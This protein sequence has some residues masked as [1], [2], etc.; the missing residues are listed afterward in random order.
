MSYS[1]R[2]F[3]GLPSLWR[4]NR[5][6]VA[7]QR[8]LALPTKVDTLVDFGCADGVAL[9]ILAPLARRIVAVDTNATHLGQARRRYGHLGN[10][11]FLSFQQFDFQG[12][13]LLALD[14]FEHV[15]GIDPALSILQRFLTEPGRVVIASLP[16]E[17][18]FT[19]WLRKVGARIHPGLCGLHGPTGYDYRELLQALCDCGDI[20][21]GDITFEPFPAL[22][23]ALNRGVFFNARGSFEATD[24]R[25]PRTA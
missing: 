24:R 1:D 11:E 7:R 5:F 4:S 19:G 17:V 2:V 20:T 10:V 16:L 15:G 25:A 9:P 3:V 12:D 21:V 8:V 6:R 22:G 23:R 14:V 13:V 18:G